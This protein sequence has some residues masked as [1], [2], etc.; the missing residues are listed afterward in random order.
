MGYDLMNNI[1]LFKLILNET[2]RVKN[3]EKYK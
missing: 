2:S 3:R 1:N